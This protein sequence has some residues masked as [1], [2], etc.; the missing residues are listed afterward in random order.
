MKWGEGVF[1]VKKRKMGMFFCKKVDLSSKQGALCTVS[2]FF[3]LCF[4]YLGV[5]TAPNAPPCL[6]A[7]LTS[8]LRVC[9]HRIFLTGEL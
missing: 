3:I 9:P 5:R 4:A 8:A 7:L 2:I 1:F 6:R